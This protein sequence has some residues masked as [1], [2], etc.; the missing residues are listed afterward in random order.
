[1]RDLGIQLM[2]EVDESAVQKNVAAFFAAVMSNKDKLAMIQDRVHAFAE[3][4]LPE[5][6]LLLCTIGFY[7]LVIDSLVSAAQ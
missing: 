7:H 5:V 3:M 1:M 2:P 6:I 4:R